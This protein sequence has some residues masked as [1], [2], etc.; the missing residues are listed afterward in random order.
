MFVVK[1]WGKYM[2]SR[3]LDPSG[4]DEAWGSGSLTAGYLQVRLLSPMQ[5]VR[6]TTTIPT[7]NPASNYPK[8]LNHTLNPKPQS[9]GSQPCST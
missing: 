7:R 3:H 6:Q 8:A 4:T 2:L 9:L 1:V 5:E